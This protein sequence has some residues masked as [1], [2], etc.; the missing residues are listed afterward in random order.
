MNSTFGIS[1][2]ILQNEQRRNEKLIEVASLRVSIHGVLGGIQKW[3]LSQAAPEIRFPSYEDTVSTHLCVIAGKRIHEH[4]D[5][6][7]IIREGL[8]GKSPEK[9]V[10]FAKSLF[11]F[12]PRSTGCRADG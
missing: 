9:K 7:F 10:T 4:P 6:T 12:F 8:E 5:Y 1:G 2:T 3:A 11:C